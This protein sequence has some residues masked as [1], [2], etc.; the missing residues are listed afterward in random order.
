MNSQNYKILIL[1]PAYYKKS[2]IQDIL[3]KNGFNV[4]ISTSTQNASTA[5]ETFK[6]DL[7]ICRVSSRM[8]KEYTLMCDFHNEAVYK[9]IPFVVMSTGGNVDFYLRLLERGIHHSIISPFNGE[10]LI[11]R[12][13]DILGHHS[14]IADEKP[15]S[16][17]FKYRGFDYALRIKLAQLVQ[18]I[19]SLVDDSVSHS[20]A[21][22]E[23]LQKKNLLHQRICSHELFDGTRIKTESDTRMERELYEALDNGEFIL[24]YQPI[25]SL[26]GGRVAGFEALIRWNHPSRKLIGPNDFIPVAERLPF[27]IPLGFWIIEEATRQL[28]SWEK[29]FHIDPPIQMGINLSANQFINPELSSGIKQIISKHGVASDNIAFEITESAFIDDMEQANIQLLR[30]KSE[31]H[32]IYMDDFGTGYSSLSYLQHFPVDTLKIDKSF[33]RWMHIDEQSEHIVRAVVG[34][35]HNLGMK[36]VAEGIEE[37]SH[38]QMLKGLKCDY[39]QG[40]YFSVPLEVAA[41]EEY[42]QNFYR[43]R[44]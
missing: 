37:K 30:L 11:S 40:F 36:V 13:N 7:I 25:I 27:I 2:V 18:F 20:S 39:G 22:S 41:A 16:I 44:G 5:I 32:P 8:I 26:A 29:K 35:A 10:F 42:L 6:P 17:Q 38:L 9:Q 24:H 15:V 14:I 23:F 19:I 3:V 31:R 1:D 43:K 21:L 28:R 33:V 12:I 34:L 4:H